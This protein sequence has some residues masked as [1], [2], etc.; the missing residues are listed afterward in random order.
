MPSPLQM[1]TDQQVKEFVERNFPQE[2]K[3]ILGR[4]HLDTS[5]PTLHDSKPE[6]LDELAFVKR[7]A[8]E[9]FALY[10][11][12][13]EQGEPS[14]DKVS[15]LHVEFLMQAYRESRTGPPLKTALDLAM[16]NAR[17]V[18]YW[19]F[20]KV[21][22]FDLYLNF[23]RRL[24]ALEEQKALFW[25]TQ[26]RP[27][28]HYAR[29]MAL[30]LGKLFTQEKAQLPTIGTASDGDHPSTPFGRHLQELFG[31]LGISTGF[32]LPGEWAV[33]QL[34]EDDLPLPHPKGLLQPGIL[35]NLGQWSHKK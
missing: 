29:T 21:F 1:T 11:G 19:G 6:F 22:V 3:S 27:P 31:I 7:S 17:R 25:S 30:R 34:T 16:D 20:T 33:E 13:V 9:L 5:N 35:P 26:G 32:R 12:L 10:Q 18:D 8:E 4:S 24:L 28:D 2:G 15:G 23:S 14:V